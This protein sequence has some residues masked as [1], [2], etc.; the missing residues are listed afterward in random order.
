MTQFVIKEGANH[1][2]SLHS[3]KESLVVNLHTRWPKSVAFCAK[4]R[5]L[6]IVTEP[7]GYVI[8]LR[9]V[10]DIEPGDIAIEKDQIVF[11][12]TRTRGA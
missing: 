10:H 8:R 5:E 3:E 4:D 1:I 6:R 2:S 9:A 7:S 11:R 12:Y